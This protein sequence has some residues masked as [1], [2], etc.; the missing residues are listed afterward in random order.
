VPSSFYCF[1]N[2]FFHP[3]IAMFR[4]GGKERY[5]LSLHQMFP[6]AVE[7]REP[8]AVSKGFL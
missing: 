3:E 8:S 7:E 6:M 5:L 2:I 1:S 4:F